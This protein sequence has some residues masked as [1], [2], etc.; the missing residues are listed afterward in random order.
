MP[1]LRSSRI[2]CGAAGTGLLL[3]VSMGVY[4]AELPP[5]YEGEVSFARDVYPILEEACIRCHGP[6]K[7]KSGYRLDNREDALAGGDYDVDILI[8]DSA[9]SLLI[10]YVAFLEEDFEMPPIGKGD[11]LTDEQVGILRA[12]IDQGLQWEDVEIEPRIQFSAT[13]EIRYISIDGNERRFREIMGTREGL[14]GGVLDFD[15][16]QRL[17]NDATFSA[18]GEIW[19]D[20]NSF[21]LELNYDRR[22]VGFI[23][24]GVEQYRSYDNNVGGYHPSFAVGASALDRSLEMDRGKAWIEAGLDV[25]DRPQ[26]TLAYEYHFRD[27]SESIQQWSEYSEI[28]QSDFVAKLIAPSYKT[29]D[30]DRHVVRLNVRHDLNGYLIEDE[31]RLEFYDVNTSRSSS[32]EFFGTRTVDNY[33]HVQG[34][35]FIRAEKQVKDW[36][37]VSGGHHFSR[38]DGRGRVEHSFIDPGTGAVLASEPVSRSI[39]LDRYANTVNANSIWGPWKELTFSAGLQAEWMS[40]EGEGEVILFDGLAPVVLGTDL[41]RDVYEERFALRYTAVPHTVL[42]AETRFQQ[43]HVDQRENQTGDDFSDFIRVTE[44]DGDLGE[45]GGG[46]QVSPWY[47]GSLNLRYRYRDRDVSYDHDVDSRFVGGAPVPGEGYSAFIT[48]LRQQRHHFKAKLALRP[49]SGFQTWLAYE[50]QDTD[51]VTRTDSV[52]FGTPGGRQSAGDYLANV[53]S[54]GASWRPVQRVYLDGSVSYRD[55]STEAFDNGSPLVAPY[56]G[57]VWIVTGGVRYLIDERTDV[58]GSYTLSVA[59]YGQSNLAGL[60]LGIEYAWHRAALGL[61]RSFTEQLAGNLRYEYYVYDEDSSG[62]ENDFDGHG[63]FASV[64]WAWN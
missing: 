17:E 41:D 45:F 46:V 8:G 40:Q 14:S 42:Y 38:I 64:T 59:D 11:R 61:G 49:V 13:S 53:Y 48:G 21:A 56:D 12:W 20:P 54:A 30:E 28:V 62:G 1:S 22:E 44:A 52:D 35:N 25:P 50:L 47:W 6:E 4:A 5:P 27:G 3:A 10:H 29:V 36:W 51:Y 63:V 43:E 2:L 16:R 31:A 23:N 24:A 18:N 32:G 15:Y 58:H 19:D 26:V 33:R 7:P 9:N 55:T 60:P 57:D 37:L 34:A 39:V